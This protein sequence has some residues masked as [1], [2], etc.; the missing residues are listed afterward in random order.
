MPM[1]KPVCRTNLYSKVV[2]LEACRTFSGRGMGINGTAQITIMIMIITSSGRLRRCPPEPPPPL[3][4]TSYLSIYLSLYIHIYIYIYM[5]NM[6]MYVCIFWSST[7]LPR[8]PPDRK[9]VADFYFN[10]EINTQ[11]I[12][13]QHLRSK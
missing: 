5:Y 2:Q 4:I 13:S 8:P 7:P 9:H 6:Y 11:G 12:S 10:V 3:H 1:P